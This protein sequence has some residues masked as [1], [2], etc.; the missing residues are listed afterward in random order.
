MGNNKK[1]PWWTFLTMI[2]VMTSSYMTYKVQSDFNELCEAF[3]LRL[4]L[5][6]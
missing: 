6:H 1:F 2:M 5:Y 3:G 4:C